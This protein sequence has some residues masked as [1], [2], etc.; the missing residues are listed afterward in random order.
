M[1]DDPTHCS[2]F[3]YN[4]FFVAFLLHLIITAALGGM[5]FV[6][7][8][9]SFTDAVGFAMSVWKVVLWIWTP[10]AMAYDGSPLHAIVWSLLVGA[11]I[12]FAAPRV[13][14]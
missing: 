10:L 14:R 1:R 5:T 7:G 9:G 12:G 11:A 13:R 2:V 8:M 4:W 6:T 3:S